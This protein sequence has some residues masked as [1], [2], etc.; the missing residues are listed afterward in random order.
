M[1]IAVVG[2][3]QFGRKHIETI[4]NDPLCELAG[5]ADPAYSGEKA[6]SDYREML[7][8]TRPAGVIIAAPNALHVPIGLACVERGVPMLVEKPIAETISAANE[9]VRAAERAKV[10]ILVGH[11]RRHN[12]LVEQARTIIQE[13][14]IGRLVA[15]AVLWLL[16]KPDDY[17]EVAWRREPGGG[18]L[19]INCIHDVDD[20]RYICG[21][22]VE[23]RAL[24]SSATRK[25]AVED[26][27]AIALRF[28]NG[29]LG[30]ITLSDATA[31][32]WAWEVTSGEYAFYPRHDENCYYFAGTAGSL[33]FPRMELWKY[34]GKTGW[35]AP[36]AKEQITVQA[37]DPQPRQLRH[38]LRVIRGEEAPRS[39]GADAVRTLEVVEMIRRAASAG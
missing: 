38:F 24:M 35:Y 3:G 15:V 27:V 39:S 37:E 1:R 22:I 14:A 9:L 19:L 10:P 13:G 33:A 6:F 28:A 16:Q 31:A 8:R 34:P 36:L 30:T 7:D 32:P 18:P 20:L 2:A 29:A 4:R 17:Y 12:L 21:E 5:V 26:T 25:F 11:H 23:V